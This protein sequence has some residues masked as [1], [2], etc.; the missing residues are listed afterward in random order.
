MSPYHL[1][2]R[3]THG[4]HIILYVPINSIIAAHSPM[5]QIPKHATH[6]PFYSFPPS[7]QTASSHILSLR[8][9]SRVEPRQ[10]NSEPYCNKHKKKQKHPK[11]KVTPHATVHPSSGATP[12]PPPLPPSATV[13]HSPIVPHF[14]IQ[15]QMLRMQFIACAFSPILVGVWA[16]F[17]VP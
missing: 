3:S 2:V 11:Q 16:S 13:C 10:N 17:Y 8:Q 6:L 5:H 7:H 1:C 14:F 9:V 12:H 15:L 4:V